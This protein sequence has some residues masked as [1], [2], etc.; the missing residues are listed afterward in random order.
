MRISR[1]YHTNIA[2]TLAVTF[3]AVILS[4]AQA[5]SPA[6]KYIRSFGS[7]NGMQSGPGQLAT[8]REVVIEPSSG[9]VL[10]ADSMNNRI[11]KFGPTG[12]F[13]HTFGSGG[14]KPGQFSS[15]QGL[16]LN[17]AGD[18]YVGDGFNKRVQEFSPKFKFIRQFGTFTDGAGDLAVAPNGDVYVADGPFI[19]HF[20]GKGAHLGD[21]GGTG[22][23][24][25]QFNSIVAGLAVGPKGKVWAGDYSG[26]RVEAFTPAGVYVR[27]VANS[28][29]AA[30]V[31]PL[32]VGVTKSAVFV[33]DNGNER[34]VQLK[35][36]GAFVR[37]FGA[38]GKGKLDNTASLALD[39]KG[40]VYVSDLDVGRIREYGNPAA[41]KG[42]C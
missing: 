13:L 32:G 23:G 17:H 37:A 40:N 15:P 30:V 27:S 31:G 8:P 9:D 33:S 14:S 24:P 11:E 35:P 22:T 39:C 21:F 20:T 18:I 12:K 16:G 7:G 41:S 38:S 10:V 28:G 6:F 4:T 19:R 36:N 2:V 25:G 26:G 34:V 29:N 5:S 42:I 1:R 3:F